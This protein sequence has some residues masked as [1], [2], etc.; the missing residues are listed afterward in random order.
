MLSPLDCDVPAPAPSNPEGI[1]LGPTEGWDH[2]LA[3]SPLAQHSA[4][5]ASSPQPPEIDVT[6]CASE[7]NLH[8]EPPGERDGTG[9]K[10]LS[11]SGCYFLT[12]QVPCRRHPTLLPGPRSPETR[13]TTQPRRRRRRQ[14]SR[15]ASRL[16]GSS[17]LFR[18]ACHLISC[19]FLPSRHEAWRRIRAQTRA[20]RKRCA[21]RT[22]TPCSTKSRSPSR[23]T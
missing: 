5:H 8:L 15:Q 3:A 22:L 17:R 13:E 7:E 4:R 11:R 10:S 21:G 16:D 20:A 6:D 2:R 18:R 23:V 14:R 9:A 1:G 19:H 12:R